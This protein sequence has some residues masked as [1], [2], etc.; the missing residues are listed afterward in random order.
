MSR[1][2]DLIVNL[3]RK[4]E[5]KWRKIEKINTEIKEL[6]ENISKAERK[7]NILEIARQEKCKH[8][9]EIGKRINPRS[10]ASFRYWLFCKK[11]G[12]DVG[13]QYFDGSIRYDI[14]IGA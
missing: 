10:D 6:R 2:K 1:L 5:R 8:N 9:G 3:K 7:L 13:H 12:K 11:C 14:K 4:I